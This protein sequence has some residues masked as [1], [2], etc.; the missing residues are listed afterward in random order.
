MR[1]LVSWL[2][3]YV[4]VTAGVADLA[5]MLSMRG[6]EVAAIEEPPPGKLA[7]DGRETKGPD[8]VID[9]EITPNRPDCLSVLG[10][11]REV[12]AAYDLPLRLPETTPFE[13]VR[14]GA[15]GSLPDLAVTIEDP[16]LCPRYAAGLAEVKVGPSPE[17]M[18]NRLI[19]AGIRPIN[20]VV[21]VTNYVLVELGHPQHAFDQQRLGGELR[22]RRARAGERVRTLDGNERLL[23]AGMLVIADA[24]RPQAIAGVMGGAASEVWA[25]TK[26]VVLESAWFDPVSVRRTSKRLGLGTEASARFE[27]GADI[28]APAA[29]L[30]RALDLMV[31]TG[32]GRPTAPVLDCYPLPRDRRKVVVR[33]ERIGAVLGQMVPDA[34]VERI[35]H[36]L[37]FDFDA[38]PDGWEVVVPTARV[39]IA[40]ET[41]LIEEAARHFGY[42]RLPTTFPPLRA[43]PEP[44]EPRLARDRRLRSLL[45]ASGFSEAITFSFIERQVAALFEEEPSLV[46]IAYPLSEKFAVLRPSLLPGLAGAIAHNLRREQRD[47][48]LFEIGSTFSARGGEHQAVAWALTG[49]ASPEH[50]S[51]T[52]RPADFFDAKGVAEVLLASFG[53]KPEF[54]PAAKKFLVDGRA[55][56]ITVDGKVVG[57]VGQIDPVTADACGVARADEVFVGELDVSLLEGADASRHPRFTPLPRYPSIVRDLSILVDAGLPAA[58]VRGTIVAAR[59]PALV[60]IG[61]FDRYRG[62]GIPEDSVSLSL[63]LTFRAPDRTLTDAEV[64]AAMELVVARLAERH[65]AVRR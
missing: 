21:D 13:V 3:D 15:A 34:D 54:L 50:W 58:E 63:R 5:A 35:F 27:R 7:P 32:A 64:D 41:D 6:F 36:R 45:L 48:C 37:G 8:A 23:E 62:P 22:I 30:A 16:D 56:T 25:G 49:K 14:A 43:F 29:A 19:A 52:G 2:R 26:S 17:W 42:D 12:S 11:A 51:G 39:D 61:V 65:G 44:P 4:D 1:I 24:N 33:R 60:S 9:L 55:A 53:V 46:E 59:P 20:N 18:A 28:S 40:R 57:L 47:V 31:L 38:R 10:I